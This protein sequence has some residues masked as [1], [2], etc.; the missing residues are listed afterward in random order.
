MTI[1]KPLS[2]ATRINFIW[3]LGFLQ[4]KSEGGEEG[5]FHISGLCFKEFSK[6]GTRLDTAYHDCPTP[7]N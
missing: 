7:Y 1:S 6:K 2:A 3:T 4:S 5:F